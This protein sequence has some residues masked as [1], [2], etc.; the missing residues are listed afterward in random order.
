MRTFDEMLS[1]QLKYEEF[2]K[3]YDAVKLEMDIIREN[4]DD[5]TKQN[6]VNK[7]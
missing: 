3:E 1:K 7:E 6:N 5:S 2:R 4:E